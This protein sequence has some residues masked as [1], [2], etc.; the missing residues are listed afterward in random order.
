MKANQQD[1]YL[2]SI[3]EDYPDLIIHDTSL[4]SQ[5]GQYNDLLIINQQLVF[6]F[7]KFEAGLETLLRELSLLEQLRGMLPLPI[8]DPVYIS[9]NTSTIGKAFMGYPII[10]GEPFWHPRFQRI[11]DQQVLE[12]L[13]FQL[14]SFLRELH[15]IPVDQLD[16]DLPVNDLTE[17]W[18]NL[19]EEIRLLL[20]SKMRPDARQ[21]ISGHFETYLNHPE[22]HTFEPAL[23]H[24]DFGS[25]NILYHQESLSISGIIDFSSAGIGDPAVDIA[26]AMIFGESFFNYY[27]ASYPRLETLVER[28]KFYKGTFALQ[29]ALYGLK[30]DDP[31]AFERGMAAYS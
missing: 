30:Q 25:G 15:A 26:A 16:L 3:R 5:E 17:D 11:K 1:L 22:L 24:G 6:R 10:I 23:R 31:Q 2:Q 8:P 20:F 14:S 12:H 28:A 27:Y 9:R 13:A 21:A 4:N 19:Y 7:P 18:A 29:E